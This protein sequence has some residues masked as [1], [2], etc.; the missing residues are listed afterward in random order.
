MH[1]LTAY[2]EKYTWSLVVVINGMTLAGVARKTVS[3][4]HGVV[5]GRTMVNDGTLK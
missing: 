5:T 2:S 3:I 1:I 4:S